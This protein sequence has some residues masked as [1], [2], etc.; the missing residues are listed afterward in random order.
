MIRP[1]LFCFPKRGT[2]LVE[3]MVTLGLTAVVLVLFGEILQLQMRHSRRLDARDQAV[4]AGLAAL[5][6][7]ARE[8]RMAVS[9]TRPA[10]ADHGPHSGLEMD[11]P[12]ADQDARRLPRPMPETPQL[13]LWDPLARGSLLHLRYQLHNQTLLR[14]A[15]LEDG[16]YQS[17][18]ICQQVREFR[19][20]RGGG[21]QL[22]LTLLVEVEEGRQH[23]ASLVE[24]PLPQA[25]ALP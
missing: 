18:P 3:A 13:P 4:D 8:C 23:L 7:V 16:Q 2:T 6:R 21:G 19:V 15:Q 14:Q 9:W 20:Q 25:W 5:D 17:V 24:L 22:Q 1:G 12:D 11:I 10:R